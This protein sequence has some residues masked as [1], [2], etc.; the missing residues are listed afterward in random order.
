VKIAKSHL[1]IVDWSSSIGR[2]CRNEVTRRCDQ[3]VV[4]FIAIH[5]NTVIFSEFNQKVCKQTKIDKGSVKDKIA[6]V[7]RLFAR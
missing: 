2:I 4:V 1:S 6:M 7:S 5:Q 3:R